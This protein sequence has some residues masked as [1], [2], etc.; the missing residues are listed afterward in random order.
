MDLMYHVILQM[1]ATLM[2]ALMKW[3]LKNLQLMKHWI[4]M[5]I[6]KLDVMLMLKFAQMDPLLGVM[7]Q[8]IVNMIPVLQS[9][10]LH[11]V[12]FVKMADL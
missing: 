6:M 11:H 1:I 8:T 3:K 5:T 9:T 12:R 7:A 4:R 10:L 2:L